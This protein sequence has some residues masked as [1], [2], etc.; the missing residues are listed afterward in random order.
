MEKVE[1][2]IETMNIILGYLSNRPYKEVYNIIAILQEE[3]QPQL[4]QK[5]QESSK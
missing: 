4:N 1:I 2:K 5:S 3:A